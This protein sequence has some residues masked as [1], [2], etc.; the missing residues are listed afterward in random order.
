MTDLNGLTMFVSATANTGVVSRDTRLCFIQ[1]GSRVAARYAG[2]RVVRGWLVGTWVGSRL[3]FRYL[4]CEEG[5]CIHGG[6]SVAAVE[7]QPDGRVRL[8]EHFTWTTRP[9]SGTNVFD[10]CPSTP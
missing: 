1:R 3:H 6:V 5:S 9:G 8:I 4:Q 7:Q 10:E 2:G